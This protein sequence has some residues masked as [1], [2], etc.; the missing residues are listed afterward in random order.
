MMRCLIRLLFMCGIL[1]QFH[2]L[3]C[4]RKQGIV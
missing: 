1:T 2:N 4:E 3:I